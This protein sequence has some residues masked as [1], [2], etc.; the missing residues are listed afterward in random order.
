LKRAR[1]RIN[2]EDT[3]LPLSHER[4]LCAPG[5]PLAG[6]YQLAGK[7]DEVGVNGLIGFDWLNGFDARWFFRRR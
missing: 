3:Q 7:L 5:T 6:S 4:T 2:F 1:D